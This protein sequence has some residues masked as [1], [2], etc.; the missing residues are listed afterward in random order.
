MASRWC[1][2]CAVKKYSPHPDL[3]DGVS[4]LQRKLSTDP[5]WL[6]AEEAEEALMKAPQHATYAV[7]KAWMESHKRKPRRDRDGE[8][9]EPARKWYHLR[10]V[11]SSSP[12]PDVRDGVSELE[13]R[14]VSYTHLTLPTKRIV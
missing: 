11:K 2:L 14:S 7:V 5:A 8:E 12:H 9:G 3:R 4:E 6:A 13:R 1:H 10:A